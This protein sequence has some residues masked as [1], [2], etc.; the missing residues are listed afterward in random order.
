MLLHTSPLQPCALQTHLVEQVKARMFPSIPPKEHDIHLDLSTDCDALREKIKAVISGSELVRKHNLSAGAIEVFV[1]AVSTVKDGS[2]ATHGAFSTM[3]DIS[4]KELS[5]VKNRAVSVELSSLLQCSDKNMLCE[6]QVSTRA[7]C[8]TT[9]SGSDMQFYHKM[10]SSLPSSVGSHAK[11]VQHAAN[12]LTCLRF[13]IFVHLQ[14]KEMFDGKSN[15]D[16]RMKMYRPALECEP[17]SKRR[18]NPSDMAKTPAGKKYAKLCK[19]LR[20]VRQAYGKDV[21]AM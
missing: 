17:G 14:I 3:R 19:R 5:Y 15:S 12:I 16:V 9:L 7:W 11:S 10:C 18:L 21:G 8:L 2:H 20:S 13:S 1:N 4:K 6:G